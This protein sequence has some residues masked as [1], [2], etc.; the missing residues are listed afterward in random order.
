[1]LK[2]LLRNLVKSIETPPLEVAPAFRDN[3]TDAG[4]AVNK[5]WPLVT[6]NL[7]PAPKGHNPILHSQDPR[8]NNLWKR[9]ARDFPS[10]K[11]GRWSTSVAAAPQLPSPLSSVPIRRM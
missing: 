9:D 6:V 3:E 10:H 7:T 1:M 11:L 5:G 8:M 4:I 2:W